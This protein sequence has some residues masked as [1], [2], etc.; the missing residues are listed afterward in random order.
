MGATN[1][2]VGK[3]DCFTANLSI[4]PTKLFRAIADSG[5]TNHYLGADVSCENIRPTTAAI[6]VGQP[7]GA[8]MHSSPTGLLTF[9]DL[10]EAART[11]HISPSI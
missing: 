7:N 10:P 9:H 11:T 2:H 8:S 1:N 3:I 4:A 6:V 5:C